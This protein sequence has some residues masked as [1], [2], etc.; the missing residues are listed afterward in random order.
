MRMKEAYLYEKLGGKKVKCNL[1]SHRCVIPEGKAGICQVRENRGGILY[2]LVYG[3]AAAN[4]VDP[5]EKKPFFHFLP[6][7]YSFSIATVGC[8]FHCRNCQNFDISQIV[9]D[10]SRITGED[11]SPDEAVRHAVEYDCKSISYTYTEPAIFL[12]YSYETA[13]IARRKGIRNNFV[14]NGFMTEEALDFFHPN[15][16]AANVDL[17]SFRET[18]YKEM[19]GGRLKPVLS[20]IKKM[21][22][23]GI[24]IEVTTLIIPTMNDSTEELREIAEFIRDVGDDVPWH[25]SR[26]HPTYRVDNIPS[27]PIEVLR[28]AR[29]IGME[30]GLRY[31]YIGNV[32]GD[33]GENT[34][35]YKC[36]KLLIKRSGFQV[37]E[38]L[39]TDSKCS[40]CGTVIDG[41]FEVADG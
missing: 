11:F 23:L 29:E 20:S 16:D 21:K 5:I 6:G 12:E 25:V 9:R 37:F 13:C 22:D 41:V 26:F 7:S 27:T 2:S 1:C 10:N 15:L 3:K 17:K 36:G 19:C 35:C 24:W 14:T 31:V 40:G 28:K 32:P 38:N 18:F 8:N 33:D 34:Y 39:I 4:N 30:A